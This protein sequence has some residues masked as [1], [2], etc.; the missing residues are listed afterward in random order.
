[1]KFLRFH[2]KTA[3]SERL[4]TE[5]FCFISE[6]LKKFIENSLTCS[7]PG[8]YITIDDQLFPSEASCHFTQYMPSKPDKI[9]IKFWLAADVD[10]KSVLLKL[11]QA[12]L[13]GGVITLRRGREHIEKS[14]T[15]DYL[16]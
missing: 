8:P 13:Y 12:P 14:K 3:R 6:V 1:M 11:W 9:G 2:K 4:R 15:K 7:K 5:K 16:K 10:S